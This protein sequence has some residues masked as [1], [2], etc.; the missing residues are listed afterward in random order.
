MDADEGTRTAHTIT[1]GWEEELTAMVAVVGVSHS[2]AHDG[3]GL[4]TRGHLSPCDIFN[5]TEE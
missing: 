2:L 1:G 4:V 3:D 5:E